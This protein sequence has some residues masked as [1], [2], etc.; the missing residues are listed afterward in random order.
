MANNFHEKELLHGGNFKSM[1]KE[2]FKGALAKNNWN[3][4]LATYCNDLTKTSEE[5]YYKTY[6]QENKNN[7]RKTWGR[8]KNNTC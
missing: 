2:K 6:F 8:I 4:V 7:L 1:D 3:E 5:K